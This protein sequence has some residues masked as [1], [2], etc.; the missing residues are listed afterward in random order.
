[1][2]L[3]LEG[4]RRPSLELLRDM[5]VFEGGF[6]PDIKVGGTVV[7]LGNVA[8][9][10]DRSS[11]LGTLTRLLPLEGVR[12]ANLDAVCI[13]VGSGRTCELA[14]FCLVFAIGRGGRADVGGS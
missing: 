3:R 9:E 10:G 6:I 8:L 2:V 11:A 12:I 1:M 5:G 14:E 13:V 7:A 4:V